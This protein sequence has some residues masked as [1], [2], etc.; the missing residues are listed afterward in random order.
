[1]A[2]SAGYDLYRVTGVPMG[3]GPVL[4]RVSAL[5]SQRGVQPRQGE[6]SH[7]AA[8][9]GEREERG[10][11][12]RGHTRRRSQLPNGVAWLNLHKARTMV[13]GRLRSQL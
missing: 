6:S 7:L 12:E 13:V 1:M 11:L 10:R 8:D 9:E 3:I 4:N 2:L 5:E